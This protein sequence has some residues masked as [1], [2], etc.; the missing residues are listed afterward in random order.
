STTY[1]TIAPS[2]PTAFSQFGQSN[3]YS[4]GG[5]AYTA[6]WKILGKARWVANETK[7]QSDFKHGNISEPVLKGYFRDSL[8]NKSASCL[9]RFDSFWTQWFDTAYGTGGANTLNR[10]MLTGPGLQGPGFPCGAV[11]PASP[12]GANGWYKSPVSLVWSGFPTPSATQTATKNGCVDE[13]VP[14]DGTYSKSCGVTVRTT[15]T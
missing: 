4:R 5:T 14:T 10:P 7:I 15:T 9:A 2:N 6:L 3:T 11:T 12:D 13:T 1:W 8:P